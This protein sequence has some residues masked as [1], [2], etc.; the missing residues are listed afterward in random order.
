MMACLAAAMT[1]S[2]NGFRGLAIYLAVVMIGAFPAFLAVLP[3]IGRFFAD[4]YMAIARYHGLLME[5]PLF[6][7]H[8]NEEWAFG[9]AGY[10]YI[11]AVVLLFLP[12]KFSITISRSIW[13]ALL[14]IF[15]FYAQQ[16]RIAASHGT[17]HEAGRSLQQIANTRKGWQIV[18]GTKSEPLFVLAHG[19][20]LYWVSQRQL[21][22]ATMEDL[23]TAVSDRWISIPNLNENDWDGRPY[24]WATLIPPFRPGR[25]TFILHYR[26]SV[27]EGADIEFVVREG[28]YTRV[29]QRFP[30]GSEV[31]HV[32][33][34]DVRRTGALYVLV[35]I[36][37]NVGAIKSHSIGGAVVAP[38]LLEKANLTAGPDTLDF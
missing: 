7:Y 19:D 30:A 8:S 9:P 31:D 5:L 35:R 34:F 15:A 37:G 13:L 29:K 26:A 12:Q 32:F 23:G 16:N 22:S 24:R 36:D 4:P 3:E 11:G 28:R 1:F 33:T 6:F 21:N 38:D 25:G 18:S 10:L 14:V 17:P 20:L 27:K 2:G